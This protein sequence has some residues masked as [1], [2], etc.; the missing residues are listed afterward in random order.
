M[1][2]NGWKNYETWNVALWIDNDQSTYSMRTQWAQDAWDSAVADKYFT[3][4]DRAILALSETLKEFIEE[5]N[6]LSR[7]A[8][9]YTDLL[10]AALSEVDY[11]EI[12]KNWLEDVEQQEDEANEPE[13]PSDAPNSSPTDS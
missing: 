3:R 4:A 6:P 2:Y 11:Y 13:P 10:G 1:A 7:T 9:L 12:A 8:T 5:Y